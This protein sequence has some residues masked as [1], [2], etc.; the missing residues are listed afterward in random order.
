[1]WFNPPVNHGKSRLKPNSW[2][3]IQS[4]R[5][6]KAMIKILRWDNSPIRVIVPSQNQT[7]LLG[8]NIDFRDNI[9]GQAL[10]TSVAT[11]W[12][13]SRKP[14]K[15]SRIESEPSCCNGFGLWWLG[16][17]LKWLQVAFSGWSCGFIP[18]LAKV[19]FSPV[20]GDDRLEYIDFCMVLAHV[21][22]RTNMWH[23]ASAKPFTFVQYVEISLYNI[24]LRRLSYKEI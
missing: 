1:M 22:G 2:E 9:T 7:P 14:N 15:L 24:W 10:V 8:L 3:M 19:C 11:A 5:K 23:N 21:T 20:G 6:S 17:G 13:E 4:N 12:L 18:D 16:S